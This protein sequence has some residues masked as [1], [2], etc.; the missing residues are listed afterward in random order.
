MLQALKNN[1]IDVKH[2]EDAKTS[3]II[4]EMLHLP[5]DLLWS[6]LREAIAFNSRLPKCVG[7][8]SMFEFWPRWEAKGE[9]N[10]N[11]RIVEP[12]VFIRFEHI[13]L[14]I[15]VKRNDREGQYRTQWTNE[16]GSYLNKYREDE[17]D[18][19]LIALG[20]NADLH[21]ETINE[22]SIVK[23]T[24]FKCSWLSLL[25]KI[26]EQLRTLNKVAFR[27]SHTMQNIRILQDIIYSFNLYGDYIID[28]FDSIP[29]N[30][31]NMNTHSVHN[32]SELWKI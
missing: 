19:V 28:W 6:L 17:K 3:S 30:I 16:I 32:I 24:I 2:N 13:D 1:K 27:D 7:E 18:V 15:E 14:I 31:I 12:D 11:K 21:N 5:S 8:V 9:G 10:T 23:Y 29:N 26:E 20:G 4:G 22:N 25:E